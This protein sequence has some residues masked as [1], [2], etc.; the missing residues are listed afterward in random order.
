MTAYVDSSV[1]VALYVPERFS[2]AA[3]KA[4]EAL[5]QVPFTHLHELE[6]GNAIALL[7]GRSALDAA[8]RDAVLGQVREDLEAQ[9][10][11]Q[12]HLDW[13][14]TFAKACEVSTRYSARSLARSLDVLHVAAAHVLGTRTLISA[15]DRQLAVAKAS[16]LRV[17]DIKTAR[18][19][20]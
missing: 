10:L 13:D 19:S 2:A 9:R 20:R 15:D 6:V 5:S 7:A 12:T 16:G 14:A 1:L 11:L 3:R 8:E 18:P 4:V 17:V